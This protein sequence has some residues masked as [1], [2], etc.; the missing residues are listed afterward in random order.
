MRQLYFNIAAKELENRVT[1]QERLRQLEVYKKQL[2]AIRRERTLV[3]AIWLQTGWQNTRQ[4]WKDHWAVQIEPL[5]EL[6]DTLNAQLS[7][8]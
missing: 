3:Y 6:I 5:I 8:R 7:E 1:R 4:E 2:D